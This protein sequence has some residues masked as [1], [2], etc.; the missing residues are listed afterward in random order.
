MGEGACKGTK[1]W[2]YNKKSG[3]KNVP[4]KNKQRRQNKKPGAYSPYE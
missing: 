4:P 1:G 2:T 3:F